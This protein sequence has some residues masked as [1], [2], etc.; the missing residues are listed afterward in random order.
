MSFTDSLAAAC[1][2]TWKGMHEHPFVREIG[3]GVLPED[4]FVFYL[5]QDYVYLIEFSRLLALACAKAPDLETMRY[6]KG[7]LGLTLDTEMELH[8]KL[9]GEH[10]I[11]RELLESTTATP[12]CLAYTSFLLSTAY[13]GI[14]TDL[15]AAMLPCAWGYHE[16]GLRLKS[17]GLPADMHYREWIETYASDQMKHVSDYLRQ[18][19]EE[20]ARHSGQV[21]QKR[22]QNLFARSVEFEVLFWEMSYRKLDRTLE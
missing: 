6:F 4:K 15:L 10:G 7:L 22:W 1:I 19:M 9:C 13:S 2:D 18:L 14:F 16:I 20:Q 3:A 8:V 21:Q 5:R 12:W 17:Q 11:S